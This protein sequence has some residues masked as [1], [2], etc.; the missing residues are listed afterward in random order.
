METK[1]IDF[2]K[3]NEAL[4]KFDSL[5]DA[6]QHIEQDKLALEKQNNQLKQ[7]N[8][9]LMATKNKLTSQI[10]DMSG[11]IKGYQSQLQSLHNQIKMHGYQYELFCCFM[12]MVAES[13]SVTDSIDTLIA[14][15]QTLKESGWYLSKS[16][17]DMR[18]LFIRTVFGDY[19]KCFYCKNCGA[20][21]IVNKEP[22]YKSISNY[23]QC[24]SC[25]T[26][27]GVEPDDSFLKAM[28]SDEQMDNIVLLEKILKENQ[29]MEPLKVFL[30]LPCEIC[31]QPMTEWSEQDVRRG[32]MGSGWGHTQC[33]NTT[34]GQARKFAKLVKEEMEKRMQNH[35]NK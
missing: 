16:V 25:H 35:Y 2:A 20:K 18:S 17:T 21:F 31:G 32:V 9:N 6:I 13:P 34:K 30:N 3:L 23:Y 8:E 22:H 10:E 27:L 15:F 24:P 33:W 4:E 14:S 1:E 11:K 5:Q 7:E 28:V 26:H 29:A 12:A 19:L